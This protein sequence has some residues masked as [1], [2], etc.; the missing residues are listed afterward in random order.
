MMVTVFRTRIIN[1]KGI[2]QIEHYCYEEHEELRRAAV[3]CLCNMAVNEEVCTDVFTAVFAQ[4]ASY[5]TCFTAVI[6][7]LLPVFI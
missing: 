5:V 1:E 4:D 3:E 6:G 7:L 2:S